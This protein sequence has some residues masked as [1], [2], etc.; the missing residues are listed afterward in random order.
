MSKSN[1]IVRSLPYPTIEDGNFSFP[2]GV[3]EVTSRKSKEPTS[4]VIL[5]HELSGAPFVE[6]LVQRG[7]AKFACLVSVPKIGYRELKMT[8]SCENL[9]EQEIGWDLK[10]VGEAPML[11]PMLL[12]VGEDFCH[13]LTAQD[14]VATIWQ[15]REVDIPKGARL[16]RRDCLAPQSNIISL[17]RLHSDEKMKAGS[18]DVEIFDSGEGIRF[19]MMAAPDVYRFLRNPQ[20]EKELKRSIEAHAVSECFSILCNHK[21]HGTSGEDD[22]DGY[23][24]TNLASLSDWLKHKIGYDWRDESFDAVRAATQIYP[25]QIPHFEE[26][27]Q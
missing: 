11:S 25:I 10:I 3:Y 23:R 17:L 13:R 26:E 9:V 18:F 24:D 8:I 27:E 7:K 14:G 1:S 19:T 6:N 2:D 22:Q 4:S 16:A 5:R 15:N 21:D 20:G 12:Y